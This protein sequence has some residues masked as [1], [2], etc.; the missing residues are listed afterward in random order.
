MLIF[1][2]QHQDGIKKK[3]RRIIVI[4]I[5]RVAAGLDLN[6]WFAGPDWAGLDGVAAGVRY[7][8]LSRPA[9]TGSLL[10][11]LISF[12]NNLYHSNSGEERPAPSPTSSP[13]KQFKV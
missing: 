5:V 2:S 12:I 1:R 6:L 7:C 11:T 4:V 3:H 9:L 10:F 8:E 13:I